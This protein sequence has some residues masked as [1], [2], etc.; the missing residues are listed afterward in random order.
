MSDFPEL[1]LDSNPPSA[2]N[3]DLSKPA[4]S[5]G[6]P[7]LDIRTL[8]EEERRAVLEFAQKIDITNTNQILQYGASA[9]N[10]IA[11]FSGGILSDIR[12]KDMGG[13]GELLAGL[14]VE[15]KDFN[16]EEDTGF[17]GIFNKAKK[18][19]EK[20]I[21]RYSK[22]EANVDK[23]VENL[24]SHKRQMLKD[25]QIFDELYKNNLSYYKE[26]SMYI[27][28]GNEKLRTVLEEDIPQLRAKATSTNDPIIVQQ[29][30]DLIAF[31][32][33]F[34]K[35]IHDLKLTR[36]ICIQ[37]GP[38][39]R[40]IQSNDSQLA[41]KIQSSIVNSIP[42]W[43]NQLVIAMGIANSKKALAA[44]KQVTDMTNALLLKNSEMLKQGTI[45]I[46]QE[47]QRGIID[48]E[49]V[50]KSNENLIA[51]ID[52]V[53]KIQKEGAQKRRDAEAEL[54][55]MELSL[56]NKLLNA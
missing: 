21:A 53:M 1:V 55:Q 2:V 18:S 27:M 20:M 11:Q 17:F 48:M 51:T 43:K 45:E 38:Q 33:R 15:L 12:T 39:I 19:T 28:A 29:L 37:M 34:D 4:S 24:E 52:E 31:A 47:N 54:E 46:A 26:V 8:P 5:N 35:K 56:K 36:M 50:K 32:D 10:K 13:A 7:S 23:I 14:V 9:Q 3:S 22:A 25:V 49:T 44:Q 6:D 42:L 16:T 30:N 40:L 41:E